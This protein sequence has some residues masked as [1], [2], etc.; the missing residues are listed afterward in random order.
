ML[1]VMGSTACSSTV[2]GIPQT[3]PS[4]PPPANTV[5]LSVSQVTFTGDAP[6]TVQISQPGYS[7]TFT[8]K[9]TCLGIA[10][11]TFRDNA[12]GRAAL[13]VT[14]LGK[15]T[16]TITITGG[17]GASAKL[18]V[19][20]T[21]SAVEVVP[22]SL[23]F[24]T[25]GKGAAKNVAVSQAEFSGRFEVSS[26]CSG[27]ATVR[28]ESNAEGQASYEVTPIAKGSCT[29]T[30]AGG[31]KESAS[32]FVGV[33]PAGTVDVKPS[34]LAFKTTGSGAAQRATV[35]Q[36]GFDGSFKVSNDCKGV[37][38]LRAASNAGGKASF[39]V[40]PV[41]KGE[42]VATFTGGSG[43]NGQLAVSVALAGDVLVDPSS[44]HF[45]A[46]TPGAA[47]SVAVSQAGYD[48]AF[49]EADTCGGIATIAS[50]SNAHG[51]AVYSVTPV[52][53]GTCGATFQGGHGQ[54]APLS[55]VVEPP[56]SIVVDPA[57]LSF[58]AVGAGAAKSAAV[59]QSGFTGTFAESDNCNGIATVVA[60]SNTGGH[61]AYTVTPVAGG[62]CSATFS[63][64]NAE[65]APLAISVMPPPPGDVV[66]APSTLAF[67]ATGPDAA[68]NVA[69]SQT[70]FDG[71][72]TE[73]DDCSAIALV[74]AKSNAGGSASYT[75]TPLAKGDCTATFTGAGAQS[76]PLAVSV[77]PLG[78]VLADPSSLTFVS[79]GSRSAK[80][81]AVSQTGYTQ[82]FTESDTC[83]GIATVAEEA[84]GKGSAS[85]TVTAVA[86]GD[87]VA[88]FT[89]G[90]KLSTPVSIAVAIPPPGPVVVN[91]NALTFTA[92][93]SGASQLVAVSQSGFTGSFTE[94]DNCTGIATIVPA[95]AVGGARYRVTPEAKGNCTATF[96]GGGGQSSPLTIEVAP[97][98]SVVVN[99][100]A[101]AFTAT[102]SGAS[103]TV[104]ISQ[105]GFSGSFTETDNCTGIATIVPASAVGG[106]HYR[107]TPE[108]KGNCAA[109]F[110]G[111][112]GESAPL[113][114]GV[115][116]PGNVVVK[117]DAL[118]FHFL[119]SIAA[120]FADVSQTGFDGHF[121]E[122][123]TCSGTAIVTAASDVNG[124]SVYRVT[125][126][127]RG[128]CVATF[129]GGNRESVRLPIVVA[130]L[131]PGPVVV[132]PDSLDFSRT[133]IGSAKVALVG[134][135]FYGGSFTASGCDGIATLTPV[136][137]LD[138]AAA[139][140]VVPIARGTCRV[141][142]AGGDGKRAPLSIVV[143]R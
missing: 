116:P 119:G 89:G 132:V 49:Q 96:H 16:C 78:D 79:A 118:K 11:V 111:G 142:F 35:L 121:S 109:T 33:E 29:V 131:P 19:E 68:A 50:T 31:L 57:S 37:A 6:Q 54:S 84:N 86:N 14:P 40:T 45:D 113:T 130:T 115:T 73:K 94:S 70:H 59:S 52:G 80:P 4:G 46:T 134:Q 13:V 122:A 95:S 139:Y 83:N 25:I 140:K 67:T 17:G 34:S 126:I 101:M 138:G 137:D 3:E 133:G 41:A 2:G 74:A 92:T 102:G 104:A 69:I 81:V 48:A 30:F 12:G 58:N 64:G 39:I 61:A 36:A 124:H 76:A 98:G 55:I 120:Q 27:I 136:L 117:P 114:I 85:Y 65:T 23:S 22:S 99:P 51:K 103:Q 100:S 15:G 18:A 63:G 110:H 106:T 10:R 20:V 90:N 1:F 77:A 43:E 56:G 141:T 135:L 32:L 107:V 38:T 71:A 7:G 82:S 75:V 105:S 21:P 108:A 93:G 72:F 24:T 53:K 66:V 129:T 28:A 5:E 123:N 143:R 42:C 8:E 87:C 88:T 128:T 9:N 60:A 26:N 125:A 91:P 112:N 44:L 47:Q 62:T 127:A 97:P